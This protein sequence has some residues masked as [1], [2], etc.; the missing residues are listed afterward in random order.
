M[1]TLQELYLNAQKELENIYSIREIQTLNQL[2][3]TEILGLSIIDTHIKKNENLDFLTIEKFTKTIAELKTNKPIQYILGETYFADLRFK[4]NSSTLIPRPETQELIDWCKEYTKETD[5][6]LDIGTGTGIIAIS[7]AHA[8][9][10]AK[11]EAIDISEIACLTAQENAIINKVKVEFSIKDILNF[12]N[13]TWNN[14]DII[15]SNPPYIK[16]EEKENMHKNVLDFEPHT[17]LFVSNNA[18]L[19]FYR[20]IAIFGQKYLKKNAYLFFEINEQLGK[21]TVAL[22][23]TFN[24]KEIE[25]RKDFYGRDRMIKAKK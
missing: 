20:Q 11:V 4:V 5:Q 12:E 1:N 16:E 22:L 23:E 3:S 10:E 21:E 17:A 25:L 2:I 13:H 8:F 14:Y 7:L 24:Y 18:P 19:L 15:I 6:I 9:S